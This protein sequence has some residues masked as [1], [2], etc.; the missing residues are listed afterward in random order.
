MD[1]KIYKI[2]KKSYMMNCTIY[3]NKTHYNLF[4]CNNTINFN[5]RKIGNTLN[6]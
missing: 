5:T 2:K 1:V 6:S 3:N 4:I